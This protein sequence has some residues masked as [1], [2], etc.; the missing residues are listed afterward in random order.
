MLAN[1]FEY[2][3]LHLSDNLDTLHL[4]H[5]AVKSAAKARLQLNGVILVD[6]I[7]CLVY[8]MISEAHAHTFT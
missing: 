7:N 8:L 4:R 3:K 5:E 1:P 2:N 6:H